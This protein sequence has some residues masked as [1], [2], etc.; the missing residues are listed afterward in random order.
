MGQLT[1]QGYV[2]E[3]LDAILRDLDAG[4]RAIYGADINLDP[5]SP[6][7]QMLGLIAQA[8]ADLEHLGEAIYKA[9]DPDHA[10]GAWLE[11]RA[12]YAGLLRRGASFSYLRGALLTGT[13]GREI[14]A[15][16]IIEDESRVRWLSVATAVLGPDGQAHADFRS[17]DA[18]RFELAAGAS[19]TMVT[20]VLGWDA[21]ETLAPAE[22]GDDEETDSALR[23]RFF[24]SR[25]RSAQNSADGIVAA[26]LALPDV[27]DADVLEN[28]TS[29]EDANGVPPHSI[30]VIVDGGLDAEIARAI[31]DKKT[32]GT[33]MR[34]DT[35]VAVLDR[36][37]RPRPVRFDRP[38]PVACRAYLEVRRSATFTAIDT[39][40]IADALAGTRFAFGEHVELTR[41]YSPIN[42]V[43]GF[44][45]QTLRIGRVGEPLAEA[46]VDI[47]VREQA[48]FATA[49]I[50][51]H[52]L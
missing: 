34:G 44:W 4:F 27:R 43:P 37:Q 32:G 49:D 33:G 17:E 29:V 3:R 38:S 2:A 20:R 40:A 6:D 14:P 28:Y 50:E 10:A 11:Q 18:G 39:D 46:N 30:N 9:L 36:R 41:L 7:G 51:V 16:A 22:A 8:K 13:A 42:S 31:W 23:G 15:G 48:R 19:I 1:P 12:A 5:D 52:V 35:T 47:G 21:I 24:R 45:V 25:A 26:L